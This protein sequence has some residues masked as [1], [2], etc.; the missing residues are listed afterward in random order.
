M[1]Y[2]KILLL[3]LSPLLVMD[4]CAQSDT[5]GTEEPV[6]FR[7]VEVMPE[8]PGGD[9]ALVSY[10]SENIEYPKK[11]QKKNIEGTVYIQF[12]VES[13]GSVT[14]IEVLRSP[15]PLLSEEAVRVVS[16]MPNWKPGTQ[17]GKN[18]NVMFNLPVRF[19]LTDPPKRKDRKKHRRKRT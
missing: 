2:L 8:F 15:D 19:T 6:V 11:A 16:E 4:I 13:D 1:K 12:V 3:F 14:N 17:R 5:N 9:E 7:I 18:V 10:L